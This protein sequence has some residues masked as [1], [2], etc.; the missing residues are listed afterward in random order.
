MWG[1]LFWEKEP[2]LSVVFCDI[3]NFDELIDARTP[4]QLVEL[5]D[6]V[7]TLLDVLSVKHGVSKMETVGKTWMGCAG[8]HGSGEN[9]A[10]KAVAFGKDALRTVARLRTDE[11]EQL[12]CLRIGI[13]TGEAVAGVVGLKKPQFCLFG[14]TVNTASRMQSTGQTGAVHVSAMTHTAISSLY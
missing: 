11:H 6:R 2:D 9:H 4:Y 7:Y 14:D 1:G 5:L 8:L 3:A 12:I 13:H 10:A